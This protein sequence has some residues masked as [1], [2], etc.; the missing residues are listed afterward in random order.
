MATDTIAPP[1]A[2]AARLPGPPELLPGR[3]DAVVDLQTVFLRCFEQGVLGYLV[4]SQVSWV[5]QAGQVINR[6]L[7]PHINYNITP[8]TQAE[9]QEVANFVAAYAGQIGEGPV[10]D[11]ADQPAPPVPTCDPAAG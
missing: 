8:G 5:T 10:V 9:A 2:P 1:Q 11:T 3:P 4:E 6:K 7:D